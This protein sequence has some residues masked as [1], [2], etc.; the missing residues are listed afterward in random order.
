[1]IDE[2]AAVQIKPK[3]RKK[4]IINGKRNNNFFDIMNAQGLDGGLGT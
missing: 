2:V 3:S 4:E 1:M